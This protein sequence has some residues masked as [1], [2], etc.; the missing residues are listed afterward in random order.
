MK[1]GKYMCAI[2]KENKLKMEKEIEVK[3][4][5]YW[6]SLTLNIYVF[7]LGKNQLASSCCGCCYCRFRFAKYVSLNM[8]FLF[9]CVCISL[10]LV[11]SFFFPTMMRMCLS[12]MCCN[13]NRFA[14]L[15]FIFLN[16][17]FW[18]FSHSQSRTRMFIWICTF[19]LLRNSFLRIFLRFVY[20]LQCV[21]SRFFVLI[22]T[23]INQKSAFYQVFFY[24]FLLKI[25][26]PVN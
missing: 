7:L 20:V 5:Q 11:W 22:C 10:F 3:K 24:S 2:E 17:I 19:Y 25:N 9:N 8:I 23:R 4:P 1:T 14:E 12:Q 13:S 15:N 26:A 21:R 18:F 16:Q 6:H